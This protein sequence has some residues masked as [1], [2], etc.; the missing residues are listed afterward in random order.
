MDRLTKNNREDNKGDYYYP[1]CLERCDGLGTSE[2]CDECDFCYAVCEK[3][4]KYEDMEEQFV[5]RLKE[6]SYERFGND[7][8]G[9]ELVIQALEKQIPKKPTYE[10]DGYAPDGT[11]VLDEW[12]CPCCGKRYEVDYDDYDYCPNC[13]QKIDWSDE[14]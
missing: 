3:L 4:G 5:E 2:K 9:G 14:K 10:G 7:G 13:G 8:I 6:A 12:I 1:E 11:F